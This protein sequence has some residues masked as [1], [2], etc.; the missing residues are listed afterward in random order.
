MSA[1]AISRHI[2]KLCLFS[3]RQTGC[4]KPQYDRE[5]LAKFFNDRNH[6]GM[7]WRND[8]KR[9]TAIFQDSAVKSSTETWLN[10]QGSD[11]YQDGLNK[12][13]LC[14]DKCLN[15]LGDYVKM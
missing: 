4:R 12:L 14:S 3:N 6:H 7:N 10:E 1:S 9:S 8:S 5:W 15:T 2:A 11:F 13:V